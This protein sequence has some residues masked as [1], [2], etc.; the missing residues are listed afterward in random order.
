MLLEFRFF[1]WNLC[2]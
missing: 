1:A 2:C